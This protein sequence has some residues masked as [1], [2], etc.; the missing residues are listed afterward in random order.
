MTTGNSL[1]M[2][3]AFWRKVGHVQP[4]L[5]N[6]TKVSN[7]YRT[8]VQSKTALMIVLE[9]SDYSATHRVSVLLSHE[10]KLNIQVKP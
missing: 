1:I 9:F 8:L 10:K 6:I 2:K 7:H 5:K 3:C 4:C